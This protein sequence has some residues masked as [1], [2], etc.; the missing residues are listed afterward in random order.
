[1]V[2]ELIHGKG[3]IFLK[4]KPR[5]GR[6][7]CLAEKMSVQ[8]NGYSAGRG[9]SSCPRE[10]LRKKR[11]VGVE[12][13]ARASALETESGLNLG[14]AKFELSDWTSGFLCLS[15]RSKEK[16]C[17]YFI[18]L[19]RPLNDRKQVFNLASPL[20]KLASPSQV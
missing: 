15:L 18:W 14:S 8:G 5:M 20:C 11:E 10:M 16:N 1:M 13:W 17:F 2:V 9:K 7:G 6:A 12:G 4:Q 19:F 3:E